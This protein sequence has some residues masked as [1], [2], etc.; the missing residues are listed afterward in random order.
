MWRQ[1][2][3]VAVLLLALNPSASRGQSG[4]V[5]VIQV[6]GEATPGEI[7]FGQISV[8]FN[9][10]YDDGGVAGEAWTSNAFILYSPDQG[11]ITN[12][13]GQPFISW[14]SL[15]SDWYSWQAIGVASVPH[16]GAP[17]TH[18]HGPVPIINTPGE[19]YGVMF[20]GTCIQPPPYGMPNGFNGPVW[21]IQF[22]TSLTDVGNVICLDKTEELAAWEWASG[23]LFWDPSWPG[24]QCYTVV[25]RAVTL[26]GCPK[27]VQV[28]E[29][30]TVTFQCVDWWGFTE[31]EE[32]TT[33]PSLVGYEII[34]ATQPV[35]YNIETSAAYTGD[36]TVC[37]KYDETKVT[38]PESDLTL[39]HWS[40]NPL[41]ATD[42]TTSVD[43]VNNIICG[44]TSSLS[45]FAL[46][47]DL[48]TCCTGR[49]GD[50]NGSGDDEPT[51]GDVSTMIDAKF[52]TGTCD[53][54]LPCLAE[55]DINQSGGAEPTCNDITIGDISIL[56]NYL[57]ITGPSLGLPNC[58]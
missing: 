56:I 36:I 35:Y 5:S 43:P 3:A 41:V 46:A 4:A 21:I 2:V 25:P 28:S 9:A 19:V 47:L 1:A 29:D 39:W 37:F 31:V 12:I 6:I 57:F 15:Y 40:G 44:V 32:Q 42:I 58:L 22:T 7:G 23:T 10:S 54:I 18:I 33:G 30:L 52:I 13:W 45:Q 17:P 24:Q 27:E 55:A 38:G 34:P 11:A 8:L 20:A 14:T 53:G 51:V 16:F 50:A 48:P 26:E 49:V